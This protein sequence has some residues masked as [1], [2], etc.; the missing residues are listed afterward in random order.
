MIY[1]NPNV[2]INYQI[3]S[4]FVGAGG[5]WFHLGLYN[6]ARLNYYSCI[7]CNHILLTFFTTCF[8]TIANSHLVII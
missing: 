4:W 8:L 7:Y 5:D 6:T 2:S 1:L 3:D